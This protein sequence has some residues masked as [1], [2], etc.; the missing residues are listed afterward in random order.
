MGLHTCS[1][2]QCPA[3]PAVGAQWDTAERRSD[4][5]VTPSCRTTSD[6]AGLI[7]QPAP[8]NSCCRVRVGIMGAAFMSSSNHVCQPMLK[9]G[10]F[11]GATTS[12]PRFSACK[13]LG[14]FIWVLFANAG[15]ARLRLHLVL[16]CPC[17]SPPETT[18]GQ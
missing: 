14:R 12:S 15:S 9:S 6:A 16:T 11:S 8:T 2:V 7:W 18:K 17:S 10:L 4:D 5:S 1:A 3:C 13:D